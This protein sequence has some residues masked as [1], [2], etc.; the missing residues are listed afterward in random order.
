VNLSLPLSR[1]SFSLLLVVVGEEEEIVFCEKRER[2]SGGV[3]ERFASER[4]R[5][6][7]SVLVGVLSS[8]ASCNYIY[9]YV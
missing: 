7:S 4:I 3:R 5:A 9:I 6:R 8:D 2:E 1:F